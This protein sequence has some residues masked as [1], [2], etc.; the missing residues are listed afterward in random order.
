MKKSLAVALSLRFLVELRQS[1]KFSTSM[2]A[3][4]KTSE[5]HFLVLGTD[6]R[7]ARL[8]RRLHFHLLRLLKIPFT[9]RLYLFSF[10]GVCMRKEVTCLDHWN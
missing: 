5:S 2:L 6:I 7:R 8:R 9:V 3:A 1:E 10:C 4:W